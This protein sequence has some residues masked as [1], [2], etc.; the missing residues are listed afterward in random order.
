MAAQGEFRFFVKKEWT[1][2]VCVHRENVVGKGGENVQN[3][4]E[5]TLHHF[6]NSRDSNR[7][8]LSQRTTQS[9]I[10]ILFP[11]FHSGT[12]IDV[13]CNS[14][15]ILRRGHFTSIELVKEKN[16]SRILDFAPQKCDERM[17]NVFNHNSDHDSVSSL[18]SQTHQATRSI[19]R[20]LYIILPLFSSSVYAFFPSSGFPFI[21]FSFRSTHHPLAHFLIFLPL[22]ILEFLIRSL[23]RQFLCHLHFQKRASLDNA[24]TRMKEL[25]GERHITKAVTAFESCSETI[26]FKFWIRTSFPQRVHG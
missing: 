7:S 25:D 5:H 8:L 21:P 16:S 2:D 10:A 13:A 6:A 15:I 3:S 4:K 11:F 14:C 20:V 17:K 23:S 22:L 24:I 19:R 9:G 18:V 1:L 12:K 26:F